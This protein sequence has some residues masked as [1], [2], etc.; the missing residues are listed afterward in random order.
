MKHFRIC[1]FLLIFPLLSYAQK[2]RVSPGLK[3]SYI[4]SRV[5]PDYTDSSLTRYQFLTAGGYRIGGFVVLES[6]KKLMVQINL[7]FTYKRTSANIYTRG[8]QSQS[9]KD[10]WI[11]NYIEF[12]VLLLYKIT[13]QKSRCY[14][15]GGINPEF[16]IWEYQPNNRA[17]KAGWS[18]AAGLRTP[19]DF[20]F[21]LDLTRNGIPGQIRY[22]SPVR[23]H[24][25]SFGVTVGYSF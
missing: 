21:Q 4:I 10:N 8:N 15:G 17:M 19:I 7:L 2:I 5:A 1:I 12:P 3:V 11:Y 6:D 24:I 22:L 9:W 18:L 16:R 23:G 20:Y 13:I 25:T 14:V